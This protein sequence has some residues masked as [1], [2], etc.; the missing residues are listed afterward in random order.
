MVI[1]TPLFLLLLLSWVLTVSSRVL[2][3]VLL[4]PLHPQLVTHNLTGRRSFSMHMPYPRMLS[5]HL[6]FLC[7]PSRGRQIPPFEPQLGNL[8][9]YPDYG[10]K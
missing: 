5:V 6:L 8:S 10:E 3:C 4:P 9:S 2:L 7:S 1:V